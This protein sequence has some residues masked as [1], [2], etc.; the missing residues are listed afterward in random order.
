ML[1]LLY[2]ISGQLYLSQAGNGHWI[3]AAEPQVGLT[4][5]TLEVLF[6]IS[7]GLSNG[8]AIGIAG[9][10]GVSSQGTVALRDHGVDVFGIHCSHV[11]LAL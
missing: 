11:C 8:H 3:S 10:C 6:G 7:K 1:D 5:D 2:L 9:L 4:G